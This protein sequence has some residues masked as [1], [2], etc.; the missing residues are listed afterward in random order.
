MLVLFG[1][2]AL[3]LLIACANVANLLLARAAG[4]QRELAIRSAIGANRWRIG[5]Q[6]LTESVLLAACGGV[7]GFGSRR[8][9]RSP[10][11]AV[12]AGEDSSPHGRGRR[13]G[14]DSDPRLAR[15]CLHR[16]TVASDGTALRTGA[17][18][19]HVQ[20]RPVIDAQGR[21]Q[22]RGHGSSASR[23][24]ALLVIT[25]VA[26]ALVL[27]V[28]ASLLIRTFVGLQSAD[29]GI[30][31]RNVLTFQTSLAG[32]GYDTTAQV[33]RFTSQ[34]IRRLEAVPGIQ[35]AASMLVLPIAAGV[36]LP[37]AIVG[38]P[39][40]QG[41][42]NGDEQWRSASPTTSPPSRFRCCAAASSASRTPDRPRAPS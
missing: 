21:Q 8:R 40:T 29:S 39:P 33:E 28:G 13:V 34:I 16:R 30:D 4:R 20:A 22:P 19:S 14:V 18:S 35:A 7:L 2:V 23:T 1:A 25:E 31:P 26:L 24:R 36:D 32:R 9:R 42:Y 10:L 6:L 5:R 11:A 15:D 3:V 27:L 37:F 41:D 12:G 38:K 17:R